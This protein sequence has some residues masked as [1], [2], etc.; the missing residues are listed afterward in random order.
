MVLAINM[1]EGLRPKPG[2]LQTW[3]CPD[4]QFGRVASSDIKGY[5]KKEKGKNDIP[6]STKG[7]DSYDLD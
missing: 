3:K 2:G 4:S 6:T 1:V 7:P 5:K